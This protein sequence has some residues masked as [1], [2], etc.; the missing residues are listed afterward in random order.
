MYWFQRGN[1]NLHLSENLLCNET[2]KIK[3]FM[4]LSAD[5]WPHNC[6]LLHRTRAGH[7]V[8]ALENPGTPGPGGRN[9]WQLDVLESGL[10]HGWWKSIKGLKR[11]RKVW[12]RCRQRDQERKRAD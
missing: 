7:P 10:P 2:T 1:T 6:E 12:G 4:G 9:V 3:V 11:Q 5:C 8:L